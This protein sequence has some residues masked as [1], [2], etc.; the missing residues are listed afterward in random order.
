MAAGPQ[1]GKQYIRFAETGLVADNLAI[2]QFSVV[3]ATGA[4]DPT[5][6]TN[7]FAGAGEC[8]GVLQQEFNT[9][10]TGY[11]TDLLRLATVA[12]SG[13]LLVAMDAAN[14]VVVGT[15]LTVDATGRAS[16]AAGA[17]AVTVDGTTPI[18]RQLV[19]IGGTSF[20]LVSFN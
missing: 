12:T 5:S 10:T 4:T 3:Q 1:Y 11:A 15:V 9:A 16:S 18:V 13:L 14:A 6:I 2:P 8:L 7:V 17:F 19:A 20:A